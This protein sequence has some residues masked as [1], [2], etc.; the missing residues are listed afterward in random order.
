MKDYLK[1]L[2]SETKGRD[3]LREPPIK[4]TL[5]EFPSD[6]IESSLI[7]LDEKKQ[8]CFYV[9]SVLTLG[10]LPLVF[11]WLPRMRNTYL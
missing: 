3:V 10:I 11:Q 4:R 5:N 2:L 9:L 7:K 6:A 1:S 8:V